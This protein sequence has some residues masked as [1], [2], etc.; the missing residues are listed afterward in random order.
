MNLQRVKSSNIEAIG[1]E[2]ETLL[3]RFKG[4]AVYEYEAVPAEVATQL[5]EAKSV[6]SAFGQLVRAK[7]FKYRRLPAEEAEGH[8]VLPQLEGPGS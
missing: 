1:H 2:G 7:G 5:L 4:G 6:G 8:V 3:V